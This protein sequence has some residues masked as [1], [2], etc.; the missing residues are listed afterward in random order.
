MGVVNILC[1]MRSISNIALSFQT[2]F[3]YSGLAHPT[4]IELLHMFRSS[5]GLVRAISDRIVSGVTLPND[6]YGLHNIV[7]AAHCLL[8]MAKGVVS[9]LGDKYGLYN[10][11]R[12][13]EQGFPPLQSMCS[14]LMSHCHTSWGIHEI[15][16]S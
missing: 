7:L 2:F 6:K 13:P 12:P 10:V 4:L 3:R 5:S 9:V 1:M 8:R 14:R 11:R 15:C 16:Q